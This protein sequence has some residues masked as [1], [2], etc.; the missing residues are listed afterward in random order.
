LET[1]FFVLPVRLRKNRKGKI[2]FPHVD[3]KL[4]AQARRSSRSKE[5]CFHQQVST[6]DKKKK[7]TKKIDQQT[8]RRAITHVAD[9]A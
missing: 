4:K 6:I 2:S 3:D 7:I 8:T 9:K 1:I 5:N